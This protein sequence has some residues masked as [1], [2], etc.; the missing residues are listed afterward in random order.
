MIDVVKR[1]EFQRTR[2]AKFSRKTNSAYITNKHSKEENVV[3]LLIRALEAATQHDS[4]NKRT[5]MSCLSLAERSE[6]LHWDLFWK[7]RWKDF[8]YYITLV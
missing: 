6:L 7:R 1:G 4:L 2:K 5:K 3:I 8:G